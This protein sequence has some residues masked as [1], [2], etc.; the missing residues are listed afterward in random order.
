MEG[1]TQKIGRWQELPILGMNYLNGR[2]P[3]GLTEKS[4]LLGYHSG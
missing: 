4:E 3:C 2:A 1:T